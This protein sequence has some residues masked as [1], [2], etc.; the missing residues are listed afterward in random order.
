MVVHRRRI[1]KQRER[2]SLAIRRCIAAVPRRFGAFE[3]RGSPHE[4]SIPRGGKLLLRAHD[5]NMAA[6]FDTV[7]ADQR[8]FRCK[9]AFTYDALGAVADIVP[10][11]AHAT[12][13]FRGPFGDGIHYPLNALN[14]RL[15]WF[16]SARRG[17]NPRPARTAGARRPLERLN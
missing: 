14:Q 10:G 3:N 1:R 12:V 17:M 4:R 7:A 15:A 6:L 8:T 11:T 5:H 2:E 9:G 16:D 13:V